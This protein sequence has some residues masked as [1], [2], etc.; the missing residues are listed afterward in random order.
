[1]GRII[2]GVDD[3]PAAGRALR[4]ALCEAALR[5][6]PVTVVATW[7]IPAP[8]FNVFR[9]PAYD[10]LSDE[11]RTEREAVTARLVAAARSLEPTTADVVVDVLVTEGFPAEVLI[12]E[13]HDADLLVV[14]ARGVQGLR[15]AVLGST[16][17]AVLAATT[18]PVVVLH[19]GPTERGL[20]EEAT[21]AHDISL[22]EKAPATAR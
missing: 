18:C 12:Q 2:V 10:Q 15:R 8:R 7:D 1:M 9:P 11:V 3:S 16:S 6:T 22:L 5:R 20:L 17:G 13:S 4:W 19:A 21:L 14:G